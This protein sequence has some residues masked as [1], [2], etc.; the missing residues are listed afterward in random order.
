M[1]CEWGRMD[2]TNPRD[3]TDAETLLLD[4]IVELKQWIQS[5]LRTTDPK[6]HPVSYQKL[7][8]GR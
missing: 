8:T 7:S 6:E 3:R 2:W 1:V 5:E 4:Y